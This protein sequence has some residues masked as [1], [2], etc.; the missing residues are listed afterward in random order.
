MARM[1]K[2]G[3]SQELRIPFR[4]RIWVAGVHVLGSSSIA[5][6]GTLAGAELEAEQ[7]GLEPVLC[8]GIVALQAAVLPAASQPYAGGV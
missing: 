2:S 3:R 7:P 6:L 5:F 1:D 8:H 4:S